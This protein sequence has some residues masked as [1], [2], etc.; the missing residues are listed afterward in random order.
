VEFHP[1]SVML[2]QAEG[3]ICACDG[4]ALNGGVNAF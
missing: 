2:I 1:A 3:T 4:V